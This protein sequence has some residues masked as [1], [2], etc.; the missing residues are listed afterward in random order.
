MGVI[1]VYSVT[2]L[3][4][5]Q[6]VQKWIEQIKQNAD[7]DVIVILVANKYDLKNNR[8]I[9]YEQGLQ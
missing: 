1:L 7:R 5:F 6:N 3:K 9:T 4:S 2:D 8:V